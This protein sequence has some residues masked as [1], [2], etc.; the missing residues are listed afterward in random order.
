MVTLPLVQ[1]RESTSAGRGLELVRVSAVSLL[2]LCV[3]SGYLLLE[4]RQIKLEACLFFLMD[5]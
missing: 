5:K 3:A 4:I 1:G 2:T